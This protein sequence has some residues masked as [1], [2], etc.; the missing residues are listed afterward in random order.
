M[1]QGGCGKKKTCW[2]Q[3]QWSASRLSSSTMLQVPLKSWFCFK[4]CPYQCNSGRSRALREWVSRSFFQEK[5]TLNQLRRV[6]R[7]KQARVSHCFSYGRDFHLVLL[8]FLVTTMV[9]LMAQIVKNLPTR[10]E[11]WVQSLGQEDPL[12]EGMA[13]HSSILAWRIP[14]TQEPGRLQPIGSQ[15]VRHDWPSKHSTAQVFN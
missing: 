12:E 10:R 14:W 13:T 8:W 1:G 7:R 5:Q 2:L 4:M 9:S 11:T 3:T 6:V 15:R